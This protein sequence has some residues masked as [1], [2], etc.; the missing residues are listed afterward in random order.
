[1]PFSATSARHPFLISGAVIAVG[2][3]VAAAGY[4]QWGG[5]VAGGAAFVVAVALGKRSGPGLT[6]GVPPAQMADPERTPPMHR[7]A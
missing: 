3:I 2:L 6:R 5:G 7:G 1:M 4:P